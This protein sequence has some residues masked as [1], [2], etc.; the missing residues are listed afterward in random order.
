VAHPG[1]LLPSI[2]QHNWYVNCHL[3]STCFS[4][5]CN[6][7]S[8]LTGINIIDTY[9]LCEHD[10]IINLRV[11]LKNEHKMLLEKFAGHIA[12]QFITNTH[13][14]LSATDPEILEI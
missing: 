12:Y 1:A 14:F 4:F 8:L 7:N 2:H 10:K 13:M 5:C 6:S 11:A 9:K 3:F